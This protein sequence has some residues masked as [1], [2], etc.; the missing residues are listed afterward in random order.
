MSNDELLRQIAQ[1][2]DLSDQGQ[3]APRRDLD[4]LARRL[5]QDLDLPLRLIPV[6]EYV[7]SDALAAL[8]DASGRAMEPAQISAARPGHNMNARVSQVVPY[9]TVDWSVSTDG[10][11]WRY[12]ST[13]QLTPALHALHQECEQVLISTGCT[14]VPEDVLQSE[15]PGRVSEMD[16]SPVTVY[17]AVF[18]ELG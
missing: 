5:E 18:T 6:K 9:A 16:D 4:V 12:E 3:I 17:Q 7:N 14:I 11:E 8:V 2:L 13:A 10:R 15:V 1:R